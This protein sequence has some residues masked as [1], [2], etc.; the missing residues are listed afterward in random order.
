[1]FIYECVLARMP[2]YLI[3]CGLINYRSLEVFISELAKVEDRLID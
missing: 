1:M 2:D 3:D